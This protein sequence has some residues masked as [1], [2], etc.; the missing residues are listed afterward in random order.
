MN[1][2][3]PSPFNLGFTGTQR[4][5]TSAQLQTLIRLLTVG[6]WSCPDRFHLGYCVGADVQAAH[7][8]YGYGITCVGHPPSNDTRRAYFEHYL[9]TYEPKPYLERNREIVDACDALI[10]CPRLSTEETRSGT[11]ATIR[12][13][14]DR[15]KTV[16]IILPNGGLK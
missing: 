13:A 16:I 5:A 15:R 12:Y 2:Q 10:A 9:T 8:A 11:W 4:G 14:K 6:R 1:K 3:R 7:L